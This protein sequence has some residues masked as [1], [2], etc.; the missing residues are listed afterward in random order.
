[1]KPEAYPISS[2]NLS[3]PPDARP[4]NG[5]ARTRDSGRPGDEARR[6]GLLVVNADD[7]GRDRLTTRMILDCLRRGTVSSV[8]AMVFME[9]SERAADMGQAGA[10]DTGLHLNFTTPFSAPYCPVRLIEHQS[11]L[12]RYLLRHPFARAVF[13]PGLAR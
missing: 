11:E 1:M 9:D 5:C 10:I 4:S 2:A 12:A 7:W 8:S 13:H 3:E 6:N